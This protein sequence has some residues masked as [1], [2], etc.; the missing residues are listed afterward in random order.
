MKIEAQDIGIVHI[1]IVSADESTAQ[2]LK[3]LLDF[4]EYYRVIGVAAGVDATL[5]Q[6]KTRPLEVILIFVPLGNEE[7][8]ELIK[9]IYVTNPT[10]A[11]ILLG[12]NMDA[13]F[14]RRAKLSGV[15]E[16]QIWP[17]EADELFDKIDI[18]HV[19]NK[20]G[21]YKPTI[22]SIERD[23]PKMDEGF[24]PPISENKPVSDYPLEEAAPPT[25]KKQDQAPGAGAEYPLDDE[26]GGEDP[27]PAQETQTEAE[28]P[29]YPLE[30][31][32]PPEDAKAPGAEVEYPLD[33]ARGG[34]APPMDEVE[35]EAPPEPK[36]QPPAA[37]GLSAVQFSAYY[38]RTVAVEKRQGL[39]VYAHLKSLL[40]DIERD[41]EKFKAELGGSIPPVRTAKDISFLQQGTPVTVMPEC[42]E[43][44]FEPASL[45]KRWKG[46]WSRFD[47]DFSAPAERVGEAFMVRVSV[48]VGGVE[49]AHIKCPLEISAAQS[50]PVTE[51]ENP[52]AAAKFKSQ[53]STPYQK[54]FISYSRQDS[55]VARGYKLAQTALGNDVFLDVDNLRSGE[56]WQAGLAKAIDSADIFQLFWS[57]SSANSKYCRYEWDYALHF[58]CEDNQCEGFIRP[59]YWINPMPKPPSELGHLNFR[60]VPFQ[61]DPPG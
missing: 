10:A 60:F 46:E 15:L 25:D 3:K 17:V 18:T 42:D 6:V 58:R 27:S 2:Q 30:E 52:L 26:G 4:V 40:S 56:D 54:I 5:Q 33:D 43:L 41:V 24:V 53:T 49:I 61:K 20:R 13:D 21:Y 59:V 23:H 29:D 8:I 31:V 55:E 9:Q 37:P 57:E 7:D 19:S 51:S 48:Q 14:L 1:L 34:E 38:P 47:F 22:F 50:M 36:P 45:T 39:Y 12:S 11:I 44:E 16:F 28:P 32:A 35:E